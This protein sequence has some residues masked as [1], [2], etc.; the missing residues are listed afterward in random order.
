MDPDLLVGLQQMADPERPAPDHAKP[1]EV[2]TDVSDYDW[3]SSYA[4]GAPNRL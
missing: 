3:W 2:H 4:R 1:F